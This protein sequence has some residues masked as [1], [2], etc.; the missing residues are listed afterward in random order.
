MTHR[1]SLLLACGVLALAACTDT[2]TSPTALKARMTVALS[3]STGTPTI[4]TDQHVFL[5]NG[6]AIPDNFAADV[7]AAGG[8][9]VRV[10]SEIGVAVVKGLTDAAANNLARGNGKVERDVMVQW[11][12][13]LEG[14]QAYVA[15]DAAVPVSGQSHFP[16]EHAAFLPFQWDMFQIHAPEAWVAHTG[17]PTVRVAIIDTGLDPDHN[18]AKGLID[19]ASSVAFTPSLNGPPEWA[20]DNFHGTHVG[21]T[22]TTNNIGTAGVAPN[23][24]LIAIKVLNSTGSGTFADVIAGL[25]HAANVHANVANL[26][27]GALFP[28]NGAGTLVAAL[29]KAVNYANAHGVLV[30]SAAGND[31]ADLQHDQNFTEIPCESG[32]GVCI[33][34]TG[35]GDLL[36]S[37]SNFG[38]SAINVAAPGGEFGAAFTHFVLSPCSSHT[39]MPSLAACKG[40]PNFYVFAIGTSQATP[41][42]SGLAALLDSQFGGMLNPAQLQTK[43]QQC[44]DDIGKAGVDP[45]FGQGRINAFNTVTGT[46]CNSS[47]P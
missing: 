4:P 19:V 25:I 45:F 16:P 14:A 21:G 7:A 39:L 23:V 26:S 33:S 27:L 30:V 24:T 6:N 38:V 31:A 1:P 37:F 43:I 10:Q 44:S 18:D 8:T 47:A 17:I 11:V 36:S 15:S 40:H 46:G 35:P 41:H 22:V 5:M 28:K 32:T 20:D 42:V 12:P 13:T 29:N 34:S 2:A 3:L 9:L